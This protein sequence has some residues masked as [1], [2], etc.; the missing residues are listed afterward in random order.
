MLGRAAYWFR[1]WDG[2]QAHL[3]RLTKT[4]LGPALLA[5]LAARLRRQPVGF[6]VDTV[7]GRGERVAAPGRK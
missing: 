6:A 4:E 2:W 7:R 5:A 3:H 1:A